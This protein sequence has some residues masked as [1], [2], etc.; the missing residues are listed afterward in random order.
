MKARAVSFALVI[1]LSVISIKTA[2]GEET[3]A[4]PKGMPELL[5]QI[6][7]GQNQT[8]QWIVP[9][10]IAVGTLVMGYIAYRCLKRFCQTYLGTNSVPKIPQGT[11]GVPR[12]PRPRA[13]LLDPVAGPGPMT[14]QARGNMNEPWTNIYTF[15]MRNID[16][17]VF[18]WVVLDY[19]GGIICTQLSPIINWVAYADFSFL[20]SPPPP[21][22]IRTV[23]TVNE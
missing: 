3:N 9:C 11:N 14:I 2:Q 20:P 10:I 7:T 22:Q 12:N 15:N 16:D 5:N 13:E 19:K 21:A 6:D 4:V 17:Q 18:E 1:I 8:N 23:E